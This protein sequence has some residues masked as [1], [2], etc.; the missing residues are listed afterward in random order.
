MEAAVPIVTA[1]I[2]GA[3]LAGTTI[4]QMSTNI[5]TERN[6]A[7]QI[8]NYSKKYILKNPRVFTSSGYPHNPPQPTI[9]KE[10]REGC[11][12]TKNPDKLFGCVGVLTYDV[13]ENNKSKAL[14]RFAIMFSVPYD[15]TKYENWFSIGL[16]DSER[17]CDESLFNLMYYEK[18]SFVRDNASSTEMKYE[19]ELSI[20]KGTMSPRA[21]S[22]MKVEI[23]DK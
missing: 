14:S 11:S 3:S 8:S 19:G 9:R 1:I 23:W 22:I 10:T 21:K 2:A 18:G 15:Y 4:E 20:V 5:N 16:F 7:I 13:S 6:V 12:F 17:S